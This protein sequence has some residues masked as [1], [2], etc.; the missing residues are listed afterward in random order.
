VAHALEVV[1]TDG[2]L[3]VV[4]A[5]RELPLEV[6]RVA[7]G[8]V[9]QEELECTARALGGF[10]GLARQLEGGSDVPLK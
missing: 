9:G 10:Q 3:Q 4:E 8:E 7:H 6:E 5:P 1:E 2:L